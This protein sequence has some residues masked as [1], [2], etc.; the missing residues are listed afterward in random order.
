[1][2]V[3]GEREETRNPFRA[4]AAESWA[5]FAADGLHLT[6]EEVAEWLAGWGTE[7]ETSMPECHA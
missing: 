3:F 5:A 6:G 7:A 4:E 2:T 1:M